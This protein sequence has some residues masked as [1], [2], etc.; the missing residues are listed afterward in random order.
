MFDD[1][2]ETIIRRAS[3]LW[4]LTSVVTVPACGFEVSGG[5]TDPGECGAGFSGDGVTCDDVDECAVANGGCSAAPYN[6]FNSIPGG[7]ILD[8]TYR[9]F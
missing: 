9:A 5:A 3:W 1:T 4:V 8:L 6:P 2:R 7:A